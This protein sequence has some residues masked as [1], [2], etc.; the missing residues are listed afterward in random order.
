MGP[1]LTVEEIRHAFPHGG[2]QFGPVSGDAWPGRRIGLIGP[3]GAGK[4][5]LLRLMSGYLKPTGGAIRIDGVPMGRLSA[6]ER[7]RL[8]AVVPQSL[9][10]QVDLTVEEVV[11]LGRL[12][13]LTWRERVSLAASPRTAAVEAALELTATAPL[14]RRSF[15]SLSGGE[16]QRV[17]LAMALAQDAPILLLDEPTAHLDPGHAR[18]FLGLV[19]S[20]AQERGKTVVMA[21]HDL[22]TV[23]LF[24]DALWLL[25][26][27]RLRAAGPSE[28]VLASPE[29]GA[30]YGTEFMTVRH[31]RT[32]RTMLL[33]A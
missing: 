18:R 25:A 5:T 2:A 1:S 19:E 26:G 4:S 7:A 32:G 11:A 17:L 9:G 31:P 13:H 21:H 12:S 23:G 6:A 22:S 24:T 28:A 3:N 10:V 29:L 15:S 20:L 27:G 30:V 16:A 8:V 33:Y 14:R